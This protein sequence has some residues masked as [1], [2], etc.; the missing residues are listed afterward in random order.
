MLGAIVNR[1]FVLTSTPFISTLLYNKQVRPGF[2]LTL[3]FS[4][5]SFEKNKSYNWFFSSIFQFLDECIICKRHKVIIKFHCFFMLSSFLIMNENVIK[6]NCTGSWKR[7]ENHLQ[8]IIKSEATQ[9]ICCFIV[10]K[11]IVK[12]HEKNQKIVW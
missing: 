11:E 4:I 7:E 6:K 3:R 12:N 1:S 5:L 9:A 10:K 8:S 2:S